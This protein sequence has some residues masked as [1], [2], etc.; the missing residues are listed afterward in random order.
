[1]R[2]KPKR[3]RLNAQISGGGQER[4]FRS[5]TLSPHQTVGFGESARIYLEEG[6][7]DYQHVLNLSKKLMAGMQDIGLVQLNGSQDIT[8]RYAGTLN[9][10]FEFVEGE[11]LLM[12]M[13]NVA[14]SSGSACT[15][16][17]LEPSYVLRAL[18]VREEL[19]HN[20]LRF[21]LGRF[22]TEQEVDM[23][24]KLLK[25]HIPRLRDMSPL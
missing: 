15:S 22:S 2:R 12:S 16:E 13:K 11:S 8:K 1:M 24:I 9:Y 23:T 6:K 18:G 10:S 4:G 20:S 25:Y 21:S 19:H 5:G 14:L 3:V 7:H 17:S